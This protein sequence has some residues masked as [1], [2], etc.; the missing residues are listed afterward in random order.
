MFPFHSSPEP[1]KIASITLEPL[2]QKT[3]DSGTPGIV[4]VRCRTKNA[5]NKSP[6]LIFHSVPRKPS[7]RFVPIDKRPEDTGMSMEDR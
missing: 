7:A 1:Q 5:K 3:L 2:N 4:E 6:E